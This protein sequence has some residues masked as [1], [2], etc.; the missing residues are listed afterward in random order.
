[1][2]P[3]ILLRASLATYEIE[4]IVCAAILAAQYFV[5]TSRNGAFKTIRVDAML[6]QQALGI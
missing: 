2:F 3:N 4:V 6:A 1:M 5:G